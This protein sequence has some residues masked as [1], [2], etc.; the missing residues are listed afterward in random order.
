M[1]NFFIL[2]FYNSIN[3]ILV[4]GTSFGDTGNQTM[5]QSGIVTEMVVEV[6]TNV[7]AIEQVHK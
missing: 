4:L 1:H 7:T 2:Y 3:Y 6:G 5:L